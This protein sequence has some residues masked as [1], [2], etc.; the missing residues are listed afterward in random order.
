MGCPNR[1][2]ALL[3]AILILACCELRGAGGALTGFITDASGAKVPSTTV[4]VVTEDCLE[5]Y[6]AVSDNLGG[7]LFPVLPEGM[8]NVYPTH[9][10]FFNSTRTVRMGSNGSEKLDMELRVSDKDTGGSPHSMP[11]SGI[12]TDA[13][14][15]PIGGALITASQ[16][17]RLQ[18]SSLGDG[19]F[20]FCRLTGDRIELRIEHQGYQPRTIRGKLGIQQVDPKLRIEL[21]NR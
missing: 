10:G 18:V 14:H 6:R 13:L 11:V 9:P 12:I 1:A 15:R 17:D 8:Y 3:I 7:Y 20:G 19:R 5:S 16:R 2:L 4:W 21:H